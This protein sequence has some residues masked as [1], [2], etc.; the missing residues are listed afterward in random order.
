MADEP[1]PVAG[2]RWAALAHR[3]YRLLWLGS[4]ASHTGDWMHQVALGWLVLDLTGSAYYLGLAAFARAVPQ[5]ALSLPAGVLADRADRRRLLGAGQ[6]AMAALTLLL[7]LLVAAGDARVGPI[8]GLVFLV[9]CAGA[10][11]VAARQTLLPG[12]VPREALANAVGL[13][14]LVSTS[15]RTLGPALAG[16]LLATVGV[17]AC[18]FAQAVSLALALATSLAMR[19]PPREAAP[20]GRPGP[21][22]DLA[23]AWRYVR[24]APDVSGLLLAAAVPA[25]L[26][27]PYL[28]LLPL[29]A[30]DWG[31]GA[32]GL[33]VMVAAAGAGSTAGALAFALA[34]DA[35]RQ[36]YVLLLSGGL[37]GAA[38]LALAAS[39][40]LVLAL[41]G[42]LGAGFASAVYQATNNT[43]LQLT[44][45]DALRGRVM[46]A[47]ALCWGMT[48]L[49]ALLQGWLAE[50]LPITLVIGVA[51]ALCLA[52]SLAVALW[53]PRVRD[54][55]GPA[56][57]AGAG[58][59]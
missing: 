42:L 46:S 34:G 28:T 4:A 16:A 58:G 54:L 24:R 56:P 21:L 6:G 25:G 22:A 57:A 40:G 12:T 15:T 38:L 29:F 30:R 47:Y 1:G 37:F 48:P 23:E 53:L 31:V 33:A 2:R 55:R 32:A 49:G 20:S 59:P 11:T 27:M 41:P 39:D 35:R 51:G 19:P 52:F 13:H 17:A 26:G 10:L 5:L 45:P 7:A 9:G 18:F 14:A 36:G 50:R 8:L 43:L 3:E 44:A